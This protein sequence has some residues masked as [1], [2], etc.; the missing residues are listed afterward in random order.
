[1]LNCKLR[2]IE[3][4]VTYRMRRSGDS[5]HSANVYQLARTAFQ[6]AKVIVHRRLFYSRLN[7]GRL[8]NKV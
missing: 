7:L 8:K 6:M 4:P 1:V 5:S 2:V 3:I